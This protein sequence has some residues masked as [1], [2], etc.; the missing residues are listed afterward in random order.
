MLY[1]KLETPYYKL[2]QR[3]EK[4]TEELIVDAR[5]GYEDLII[6]KQSGT[7]DVNIDPEIFLYGNEK[8]DHHEQD[9]EN[10]KPKASTIEDSSLSSLSSL[11]T[12]S[13]ISNAS[14][15]DLPTR[16]KK[17]N[18]KRA[19]NLE[20]VNTNAK[21]ARRSSSHTEEHGSPKPDRRMTRSRAHQNQRTLRTRSITKDMH[22][23]VKIKLPPQPKA[24]ALETK[25]KQPFKKQD[26]SVVVKEENIQASDHRKKVPKVQFTEQELVWGRVPGFPPHPAY[27]VIPK[28]TKRKIPERVLES[29]GEN[30][31]VLVWFLLVSE[32]HTW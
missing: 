22:H 10:N 3:L 18:L 28:E 15:P 16:N 25:A 4:T 13:T 8:A 11:S 24:G 14:T 5:A 2:A 21:K 19:N 12:P 6:R 7:L 30:N 17:R 32:S 1:N 31:D 27:I 26:V 29:K 9:K 20:N 23:P